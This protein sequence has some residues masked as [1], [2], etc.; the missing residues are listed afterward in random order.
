MAKAVGL[1][2]A[3]AL[4]VSLPA[5]QPFPAEMDMRL[6]ENLEGQFIFFPTAAIA[7]TPGDFGADFEDV[8]FAT[9]D[10]L[11]LN[12]WFVP[13]PDAAGGPATTVL[14]FHGNGG[15]LG[16][17]AVDVVLLSR[18]LGVNVFIFDYRGYGRSQGLPSE[19]G[20]YQDAR[21]ALD[22]LVTR[23]DVDAGRVV[24]LG[25]SLGTGVAVELAAA[26]PT[27]QGPAGLVLV[28]PL[29]GTK[30]MAR[31]LNP[32]NPLRLVVPNRFDNL[33]RIG[34]VYCPLLVI[35]SDAD[36]IIP[37][38]QARRVYAAANPPKSFH[39]WRG[40]GHNDNLGSA[41]GGRSAEG[42]LWAALGQFLASIHE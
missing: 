26:R 12:G 32:Y 17:R 7:A 8:Y 3:L 30:D 39:L 36:E 34:Q 35:H 29:T 2:T 14:W 4:L 5:S 33:R 41:E 42:G 10:G 40:A 1:A 20:L 37:V 24:Y 27:E 21:A 31:V 23:G 11:Q 28:S 25:R 38:G 19:A 13:A 6:L 16:H 15:N 22:Y 9:A 18:R